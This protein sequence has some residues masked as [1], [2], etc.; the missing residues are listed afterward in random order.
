MDNEL[1]PGINDGTYYLFHMFISLWTK[2][3]VLKQP[4][5]AINKAGQDV[6]TTFKLLTNYG[7]TEVEAPVSLEYQAAYL[8]GIETWKYIYDKFDLYKILKKSLT[9][10]S[11]CLTVG[12]L[13]PEPINA[14]THAA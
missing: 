8:A 7:A 10:Y 11:Y 4:T 13:V 6:Y 3:G 9:V 5:R 2:R 1:D 14:F 12:G